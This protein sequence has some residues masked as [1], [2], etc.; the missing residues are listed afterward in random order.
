[1][2][3]DYRLDHDVILNSVDKI[4]DISLENDPGS[5]NPEAKRRIVEHGER[6]RTATDVVYINDKAGDIIRYA[7]MIYSKGSTDEW[8]RIMGA[9]DQIIIHI[10]ARKDKDAENSLS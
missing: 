7:D 9:C 10:N 4:L 1:M 6:I 2:Q 3:S 8:S 5:P